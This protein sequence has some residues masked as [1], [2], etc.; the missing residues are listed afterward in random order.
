MNDADDKLAELIARYV[1]LEKEIQKLIRAVSSEFCRSC[2]SKCCREEMCR[3]SLESVFLSRL[4]KR[5]KKRYD[6]EKGWAGP[7]GCR[8]DYGRPPVCYDFFCQDILRS[9]E[10]KSADIQGIIEDFVAVGRRTHGGAHLIC[11]DRLENISA[12]MVE[13]MMFKINRLLER[14][15]EHPSRAQTRDLG[16]SRLKPPIKKEGRHE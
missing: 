9:E 12:A 6:P 5:Q 8:L 11:I 4:V 10:F 14:I 16:G 1:R 7:A 3:E 15:A 13:K 2:L